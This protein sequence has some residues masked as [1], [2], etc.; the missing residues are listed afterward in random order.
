MSGATP[1][2]LNCTGEPTTVT[3]ATKTAVPVAAPTA[4]GVNTTLIVQFAPAASVVPQLGAPPGKVPVV[5]RE[6][7]PVNVTPMPVSVALPV[8]CKVRFCEALGVGGVV[9][10][11]LPN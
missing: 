3:L 7:E 10:G 5:I 9:T 1:A 11:T 6:N 8:L 4:V 2:P